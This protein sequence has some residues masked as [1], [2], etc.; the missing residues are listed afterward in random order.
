MGNRAN[1]EFITCFIFL[2]RRRI[3]LAQFTIIDA[4]SILGLRSTGVQHLPEALKTAGLMSE[5]RA[6]YGGRV[7]P[8]SYS[9]ERDKS[10]LLLNPDSIRQFSLQLAD[11]VTLVLHKKRF[12]LVLGGDC[13]ILIGSLL[14]L[15]RLG[16]YG[17]FFIDGHADFY[18]PQA[19]PTGEVADMDL[20]IVS[21]R[22]PDVLTNIDGLKPLVRD[23]DIIVFGYRD[24]EQSASY[25]S[26]DVRDTNMH[27]FDL[28]YV[29]KLGTINAAASQAVEILVN[30]ELDGFWIHLDAD[31][32]DDSIMPAVDYRLGGGGLSFAELSEL[33]KSL[34]VSGRAV[35]MNITIFNPRLDLDGSITRRFVSS[36]VQGLS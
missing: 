29:R 19:S 9:S 15:R 32:L 22:G 18:Q 28:P 14:A 23:Q 33:L 16:K 34:I 10:T 17:L 21:G 6:E 26:Q 1:H 12:P 2:P 30:H 20:A 7:S 4:P 36:L 31:V 8:L 3:H 27:A 24:A 11:S 5:L 13:S 25:R 35:G